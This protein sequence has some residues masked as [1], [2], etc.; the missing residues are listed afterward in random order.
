MIPNQRLKIEDKGVDDCGVEDGG[1][2][3][4]KPE[5]L[6]VNKVENLVSLNDED[7]ITGLVPSLNKDFT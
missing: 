1:L 4:S 5:M 3:D 6:K 7:L 2:V